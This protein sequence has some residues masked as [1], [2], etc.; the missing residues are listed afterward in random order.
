MHDRD[1]VLACQLTRCSSTNFLASGPWCGLGA[2]FA[3]TVVRNRSKTALKFIAAL[4]CS[5]FRLPSPLGNQLASLRR[6][7][8]CLVEELSHMIPRGLVCLRL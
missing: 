2:Q 5:K 6:S 7:T 3:Q 8:Q 4:T 1:W